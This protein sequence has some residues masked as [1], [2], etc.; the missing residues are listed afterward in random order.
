MFDWGN[1]MIETVIAAFF[2]SGFVVFYNSRLISLFDLVRHK[3]LNDHVASTGFVM[4]MVIFCLL[5][6]WANPT[7]ST[8]YLNWA[9]YILFVPL[10]DD[11]ITP[12][13]FL[14]RA[15]AI[16]GFWYYTNAVRANLFYVSLVMVVIILSLMFKFHTLIH[17]YLLLNIEVT[18]WI[19]IA[20][21]ITQTQ[22]TMTASLMS[23]VMFI[24]MNWF[25]AMYWSAERLANLERNHLEQQVNS[26]ALTKAGSLFAFKADTQAALAQAQKSTT[27]LTL[28]MFDIDHF[29]TINDTYGH[30]AGNAVLIQ[31]SAM[32]QK[33]VGARLYRTGGEEFNL[34]FEAPKHE[35]LPLMQKIHRQVKDADFTYE[36]QHMHVTLSMGITGLNP[37]DMSFEDVYERADANLYLSKRSGRDCITMDG[38]QFQLA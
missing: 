11:N 17:K 10:V 8:A 5:A 4:V 23:T 3:K 33:A 2:I 18:A 35:I 13:E 7:N 21:W 14:V 31:V 9:L 1:W 34:M 20:F 24:L 37:S 22:L 19:G 25:T 26:D 30:A 29:K 32:V 28:V 6:T 16:I 15:A 12:S 38:E 27:P 36:G